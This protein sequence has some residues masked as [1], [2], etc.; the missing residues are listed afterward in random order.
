MKEKIVVEI[1]SAND[2]SWYKDLIGSKVE[3]TDF[4]EFFYLY[5]PN[6]AIAKDNCKV[7]KR[8]SPNKEVRS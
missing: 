3:V 6:K 1:I 7:V 5:K 2:N 8:S 4:T